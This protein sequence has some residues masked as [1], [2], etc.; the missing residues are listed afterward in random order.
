MYFF[1]QKISEVEIAHLIE[2]RPVAREA[3][4]KKNYHVIFSDIQTSKEKSF[5]K[6]QY[7]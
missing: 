4:F 3:L 2:I 7:K 1:V 6:A 5:T